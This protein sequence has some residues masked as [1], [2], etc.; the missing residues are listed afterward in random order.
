MSIAYIF[1]FFH[2]ST[3][4]NLKNHIGVNHK[5]SNI[6][7]CKL[8]DFNT[9]NKDTLKGHEK[10][11]TGTYN[12]NSTLLMEPSK[13]VMYPYHIIFLMQPIFLEKIFSCDKCSFT[14]TSKIGLTSHKRK[15]HPA[16]GSRFSCQYC[17]F[18]CAWEGGLS[19]HINKKHGRHG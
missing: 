9:N 13:P 6:F 8:C 7:A 14:H 19:A 12:I 18:S 5:E 11:H 1:T 2:V 15:I 17:L 4:A 16:T 3:K 10:T